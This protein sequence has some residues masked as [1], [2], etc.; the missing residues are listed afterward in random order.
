MNTL[1]KGA[2]GDDVKRLQEKLGVKVDGD[3]GGKTEKALIAWQTANGIVPAN[4]IADFK[5]FI[6]L[7]LLSG[8][9][10][11]L[12]LKALL[13]VVPD[14][15]VAQIID[16]A[17]KFQITTNLRLAHFLAQCAVESGEFK[18]VEENLK[19]SA[20]RLLQIFPKKFTEAEAKEY[21][22]KPEKIANRVYANI[23]GNGPE[24]SGDGYRYRGRGYI[25][26]TGK[27]NYAAFSKFSG[28]DC[29]TQPDLIATTYPLASAAD[30]FNRTAKIWPTCD[31]GSDD[32]TVKAVTKK[33]N[34]GLL[35]LQER[36]AYF[37]KYFALLSK[38]G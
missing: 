15:V 32:A 31:K 14:K 10:A 17:D 38:Q 11:A 18:V 22:G 9:A 37:K 6:K 27:D 29:I 34:K 5:T 25:Q 36:T 1:A 24:A 33:V 21:G 12:S 3:F 19:Y 35:G 4:G 13:G 26:L 20:A 23:I 2:K 16:D 30:Y 7:G 28:I 8:A